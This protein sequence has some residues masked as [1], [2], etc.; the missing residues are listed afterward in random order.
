MGSG[1]FLAGAFW[2][3]TASILAWVPYLLVHPWY[4]LLAF[5]PLAYYAYKRVKLEVKEHAYLFKK[6]ANEISWY[7]PIVAIKT[8][9]YYFRI[10]LFPFRLGWDV[11]F[12]YQYGHTKLATQKAH[13]INREFWIG[14]CSI[15]LT[16]I[17][18]W[19]GG[20]IRFGL[21]WFVSNILCWLNIV[22][23]T[24]K[25]QERYM[26]IPVIGLMYS[27]TNFLYLIGFQE[28]MYL[29]IG[30]YM[31]KTYLYSDAF[32]SIYNLVEYIRIEHDEFPTYYTVKGCEYLCHGDRNIA[33][34]MLHQALK[35]ADGD[36][37]VPRYNLAV[38]YYVMGDLAQSSINY[39]IA[40]S[41]LYERTDAD[42]THVFDKFAVMLEDATKESVNG[43]YQIRD[44]QLLTIS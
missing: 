21:I 43:H 25:V 7:T 41:K 4:Y 5:I 39:Q 8:Y 32:K 10:G 13:S 31:L 26:I 2:G 27:L 11:P 34:Y 42:Y 33:L 35:R 30:A 38:A 19:Y 1:I 16:A 40:R 24:G 18:I 14:I 12:L 28:I 9:G 44:I 15:I 36:E 22:K 37:C 20:N 29:L 17:G 23:T 3:S 6:S